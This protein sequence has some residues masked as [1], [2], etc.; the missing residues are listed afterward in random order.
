MDC[1]H[2]MMSIRLHQLL[3]QIMSGQWLDCLSVLI[4]LIIG[5]VI[6]RVRREDFPEDDHIAL[7]ANTH[8]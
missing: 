3:V 7:H 6:E 8:V 4:S 5:L 2:E 1:L